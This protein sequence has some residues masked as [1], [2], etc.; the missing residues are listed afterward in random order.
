VA[1]VDPGLLVSIEQA[2]K[3]ALQAE[4]ARHRSY[5]HIARRLRQEGTA[6]V[7]F[8]VLADGRLV[9]IELVDSSG[10]A[11][12][13]SAAVQAVREVHRFRPIPSELARERWN[14]SVPLNFRLL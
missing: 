3:S 9:D 1:P 5:P 8:V 4:I 6:E 2:Y 12:L 11:L 14:L 7:G 13:D 10:H